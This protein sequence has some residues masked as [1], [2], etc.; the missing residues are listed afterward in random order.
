M[1]EE[2]VRPKLIIVA[3]WQ[4]WLLRTLNPLLLRIGVMVTSRNHSVGEFSRVPVECYYRSLERL[5][6]FVLQ[7]PCVR[8]FP[9]GCCLNRLDEEARIRLQRQLVVR[10]FTEEWAFS[11]MVASAYPRTRLLDFTIRNSRFRFQ[12]V[13]SVARVRS[14]RA[15]IG[16]M[17]STLTL[18][19]KRRQ[20]DDRP[21]TIV[22]GSVPMVAW[23]DENPQH[24]SL[25]RFL[26]DLAGHL[27]L[28]PSEIWIAE[29]GRLGRCSAISR[30]PLM[31]S[32]RE[33]V[34]VLIEA[35]GT[36]MRVLLGFGSRDGSALA[37]AESARYAWAGFWIQRAQPRCVTGTISDISCD[38][39]VVVAARMQ[40][41]PACLI[42][43]A[44]L[45][46]PSSAGPVWDDLDLGY[47]YLL[48]SHY[49]VWGESIARLFR[50]YAA[51]G[52]E[53]LVSGPVVFA[54]DGA[55]ERTHDSD[56]MFRIGVF[57]ISPPSPELL[58]S[59]GAGRG[60]CTLEDAEAFYADII[61][62]LRGL[63]VPV[64]LVIKPKRAPRSSIVMR[65][66]AE[67]LKRTQ[68]SA[69]VRVHLCDA[70]EN[71]WVVMANV[72]AVISM[73]FTAPTSMGVALGRPSIFYA[74]STTLRPGH[75]TLDGDCLV[76]GR[77]ALAMWLWRASRDYGQSRRSY[78][79][80]RQLA[81]VLARVIGLTV[82]MPASS[83]DEVSLVR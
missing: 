10:A 61:D 69:P 46:V 20:G 15:L 65:G 44:S 21:I 80:T 57:D 81:Q 56:G 24:V 45:N 8:T 33:A 53:V 2:G 31:I 43:Y 6:D 18:L 28:D 71:P 29:Y 25:P 76:T 39:A 40:G 7:L 50:R 78:S 58:A 52:A 11:S 36:F 63:P 64:Q 82:D 83:R 48:Y 70:N 77:E 13:R 3:G 66:Y 38:P 51:Q 23:L 12:R 47:R 73:P 42:A 26:Y 4:G 22:W 79:G 67:L 37:M 75:H 19:L 72:D 41:I 55:V 9:R 35:V 60:W 62:G 34:R 17:K 32:P 68:D 27:G 49:V 54:P 74:S 5:N 16:A 1:A 30:M 14:F 59:I